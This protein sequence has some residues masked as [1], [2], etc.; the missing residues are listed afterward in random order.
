V[1]DTFF[2]SV[3]TCRLRFTN[4]HYELTEQGL[5]DVLPID[6][7]S[8]YGKSDVETCTTTL[9]DALGDARIAPLVNELT[10]DKNLLL[11]LCH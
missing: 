9:E 11:Y 7:T 6:H 3:K 4:K 8:F 10:V 5:S 1:L 2:D